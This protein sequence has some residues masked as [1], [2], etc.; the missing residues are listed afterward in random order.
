MEK[1]MINDK[2][3][4]YDEYA[5]K[6]VL[7]S[8]LID[9][10]KI[11]DVMP[12]LKWTDFFSKKN[13]IIFKAMIHLSNDNKIDVITLQDYLQVTN[14]INDI[15]GM[16]YLTMLADFVPTTNNIL[17]YSK[18][19]INKSRLRQ[20]IDIANDVLKNS[21]NQSKNPYDILEQAEKNFD[22]ILDDH[23]KSEDRKSVV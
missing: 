12:I 10:K 6:A 14:Q 4:P 19:I 9:D 18:I 11:L 23:N 3:I 22:N 20:L 7:G 13:Q 15:G 1:I 16:S 5:E 8:I 17:Y 2:N 21:Y